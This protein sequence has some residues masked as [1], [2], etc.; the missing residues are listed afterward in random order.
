M[1]CK[2]MWK[3]IIYPNQIPSNPFGWA[4][5]ASPVNQTSNG[6]SHNKRWKTT[7]GWSRCTSRTTVT[8]SA[9]RSPASLA[10]P[11]CPR[12]SQPS[13]PRMRKNASRSSKSR[14]WTLWCT[15]RATIAAHRAQTDQRKAKTPTPSFTTTWWG[16]PS[17]RTNQH[18]KW[19]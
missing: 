19:L 18:P 11:A 7:K 3:G 15:S 5:T 13:A 6:S 2:Q 14:P 4:Q 16:R 1:K 10:W 17:G 12:R 8:T 9:S